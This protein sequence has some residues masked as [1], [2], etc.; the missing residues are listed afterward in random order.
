MAL[1][2]VEAAERAVA[3]RAEGLGNWGSEETVPAL[4]V[5]FGW[6]VSECE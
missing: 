6:L 2:A 3:V 4:L 1:A 5:A